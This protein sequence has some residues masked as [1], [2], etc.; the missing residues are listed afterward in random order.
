MF[1]FPE[2]PKR[3]F[4]GLRPEDLNDPKSHAHALKK[5]EELAAY[6]RPRLDDALT[7][8]RKELSEKTLAPF[9]TAQIWAVTLIG[10]AGLGKTAMASAI[11]ELSGSNVITYFVEDDEEEDEFLE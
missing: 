7:E 5:A 1:P 6:H 9:E 2:P 8:L 11:S 3:L 10:P 4:A